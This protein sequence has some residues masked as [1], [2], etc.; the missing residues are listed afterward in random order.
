MSS[1][2]IVARFEAKPEHAE[3]VAEKMKGSLPLAQDEEGTTQWFLV[4]SSET[5]FWVFD[6][7]VDEDGRQA[8][9]NGKIA[10][11]LGEWAG[12]LLASPPEIFESDVLAQT[13]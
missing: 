7:F 11:K 4:R 8:H 9:L 10:A 1:P 5:T 3:E 6:T 12:D 2:A 13:T